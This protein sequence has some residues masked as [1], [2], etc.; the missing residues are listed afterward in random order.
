MLP[1]GNV[2][3][4]ICVKECTGICVLASLVGNEFCVKMEEILGCLWNARW[5]KEKSRKKSRALI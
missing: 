4:G 3:M 5:Y 2:S 1:R